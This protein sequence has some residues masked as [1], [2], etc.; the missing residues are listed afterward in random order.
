MYQVKRIPHMD[1]NSKQV[2]PH[3]SLW[4]DSTSKGK[5]WRLLR[6]RYSIRIEFEQSGSLGEFRRLEWSGEGNSIVRVY[7]LFP[8]LSLLLS[9]SPPLT[10]MFSIP[11]L[12][13]R[14]V[15]G[16]GL[17]TLTATI[18]DIVALYL[19]PNR[20]TYRNHVYE[21]SEQIKSFEKKER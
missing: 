16:M 18:I 2:L 5:Q 12:L 8:S 11:T 14:L 10:G 15:S 6:K 3:P 19:L 17:L 9:L 7:S 13:L 4:G 1:Y 21:E 20:F